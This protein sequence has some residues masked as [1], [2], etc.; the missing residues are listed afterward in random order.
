MLCPLYMSEISPPEV[1]G[2][3]LSIEQFSIVLGVV[4]GFWIGFCTRSSMISNSLSSFVTRSDFLSACLVQGSASWRIPLGIQLVP[5]LLLA[6]GCLYLPPSPRL[7]VYKGRQA[8]ALASLAQLR[9][10][11]DSDDPL[12]HVSQTFSLSLMFKSLIF[13]LHPGSSSSPKW[14]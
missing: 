4:V 5:G 3:L 12:V 11:P 2:S 9:Q 13:S 14:K 6:V 8:E 10:R 1:R 7:L